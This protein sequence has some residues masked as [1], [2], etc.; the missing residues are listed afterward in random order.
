MLAH[1]EG[2]SK[3]DL[4]CSGTL[5]S[6]RIPY[7][8]SKFQSRLSVDLEKN[9]FCDKFSCDELTTASGF[10][11]YRC[12]MMDRSRFCAAGVIG[13]TAGPFIQRDEFII[14]LSN[15][16]FWRTM[17]GEFGDRSSVPYTAS[18]DGVC[19]NAPFTDVKPDHP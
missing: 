2:S 1:G 16:K 9:R 11:I 6:T 17:S 3:F 5:G 7:V 4:I 10:L 8:Y 15:G 14:D 19:V 12:D 18:Y 13:S